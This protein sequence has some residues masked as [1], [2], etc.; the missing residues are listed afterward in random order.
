MMMK[1]IEVIV[2]PQ[3][4]VKVETKGFTGG[5]CREASKA[6]EEALGVKG[7]ERMTAEFYQAPQVSQ[8]QTTSS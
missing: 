6:L 3:G 5:S 7:E 8:S 4:E 1:T 2:N